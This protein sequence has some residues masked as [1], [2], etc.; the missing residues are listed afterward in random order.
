MQPRHVSFK[1][2]RKVEDKNRIQSIKSGKSKFVGAGA[3][4][5]K[6]A[7]KINALDNKLFT[8]NT[9]NE[10]NGNSP[11]ANSSPPPNNQ[12]NQGSQLTNNDNNNNNN[13]INSNKDSKSSNC[14]RQIY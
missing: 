8:N 11:T 2:L 10:C 14:G 1:G 3:R 12:N 6:E 5:E 9:L 7:K 4:E 13:T